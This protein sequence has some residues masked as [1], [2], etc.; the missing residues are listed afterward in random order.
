MVVLLGGNTKENYLRVIST[1]KHRCLTRPGDVG[2]FEVPYRESKV[3][4]G[5]VLEYVIGEGALEAWS[6]KYGFISR[7]NEKG[8]MHI[9]GI[10]VNFGSF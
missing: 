9:F 4:V 2:I 1:Q 8:H 3:N 10:G 7:P 5:A 6:I